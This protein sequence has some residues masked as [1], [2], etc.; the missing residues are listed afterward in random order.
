MTASSSSFALI[1]AATSGLVSKIIGAVRISPSREV[2]LDEVVLFA[3]FGLSPCPT[4]LDFSERLLSR[5]GLEVRS[6]SSISLMES[7]L[8]ASLSI[9]L[10]D[11]FIFLVE[12][13]C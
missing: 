5:F 4:A 9:C 2:N 7:F 11:S 10:E 6:A 12:T 3:F 13:G 8:L 1:L